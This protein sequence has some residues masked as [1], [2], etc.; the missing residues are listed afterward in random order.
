MNY[1]WY[2][3]NG[4]ILYDETIKQTSVSKKTIPELIITNYKIFE[5]VLLLI[6]LSYQFTQFF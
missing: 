6:K 4:V 2:L 5:K 3:D 1:S